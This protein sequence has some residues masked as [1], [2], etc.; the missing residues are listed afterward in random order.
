[1]KNF[2]RIGAALLLA[3]SILI[4]A[5]PFSTPVAATTL[6]YSKESNSGTRDVVCVTLEGTGAESY[7]IGN[8]TYDKLDDLSE[9]ALFDALQTLMRSTHKKITTY[10]DCRDYAFRTDCQNNNTTYGTTLYTS[11]QMTS[12]EH[13]KEGGWK[14]NREHVWPKSLGP[15]SNSSDATKNGGSD[16]HHIRPAEGNVNT[17]RSNR[18]FGNVSS[19]KTTKGT[20]SGVIGGTYTSTYFEPNDNVKGDV[21]RICLYMYVRWNSDWGCDRL[22]KVF[23]S[24]EVLLEW[25]ESD[26]VDTWEMGR[27]EVVGKIQGNRNVFIDYPELAWLML[28]YDIPAGMMTPSGNALGGDPDCKHSST[29]IKNKSDATCGKDGYTGDTYCKDCKKQTSTGSVIKATGKHSF[30]SWEI[31]G[32]KQI[33]I[34]SVCQKREE[35][36]VPQCQHSSTELKNALAPTCGVDGYTGDTV[37]K[38]CGSVVTVGEPIPATGDHKNTEQRDATAPTCGVDGT[39]GAIYCTDCGNKVS[40]G[41]PIPATGDHKS[42]VIINEKKPTCDGE[43]YSGDTYCNDCK[44]VVAAGQKLPATGEHFFTEG[45]VISKPTKT[46]NGLRMDKC[47]NC[48]YVEGVVLPATGDDNT[49]VIIIIAAASVAVIAA[50]TVTVIIIKKKKAK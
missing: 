27:N 11:F 21:A 2:K 38:N 12:K 44:K 36:A 20:Y 29:E 33:R 26:P 50:V 42:T 19:G 37:C 1:M 34:C 41:E 40:D 16:L 6:V 5:I 48:G 46:E 15:G 13:W 3:F 43:G 30:G 8:Y 24:V 49:A 23:E 35:R 45:E 32:D 39:T 47:V 7:Y 28:G 10:N 22:T 9:D 31:D 25:C 14:C 4:T 17:T 18:L